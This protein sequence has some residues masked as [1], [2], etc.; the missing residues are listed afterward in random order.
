MGFRGVK[1]MDFLEICPVA[2]VYRPARIPTDHQARVSIWPCV[3]L[4]RDKYNNI[5]A[6]NGIIDRACHNNNTMITSSSST[7]LEKTTQHIEWRYSNPSF[8]RSYPH[9]PPVN[10]QPGGFYRNYLLSHSKGYY[11]KVLVSSCFK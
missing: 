4:N 5:K 3:L 10:S 1:G 8:M 9:H 2:S 6:T 7:C 11:Q